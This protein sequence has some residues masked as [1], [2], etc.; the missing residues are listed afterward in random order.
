MVT[1][2]NG[3]QLFLRV[4]QLG[5]WL[6]LVF[7]V[8]GQIRA[9]DDGIVLLDTGAEERS[10]EHYAGC[11]ERELKENRLKH[12]IIDR[13]SFRDAL[14]PFF[15]PNTS[16]SNPKDMT[17]L[18]AKPRVA[19]TLVNLGVRYVVTEIWEITQEG[20]DSGFMFCA[21]EAGCWGLGTVEKT[22]DMSLI[23]WD[24]KNP[25]RTIAPDISAKGQD[26][27]VGFILPIPFLAGTRSG[28]CKEMAK[29]IVKFINSSEIQGTEPDSR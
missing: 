14:F 13:A 4:I 19:K 28:A 11:L 27:W 29:Q 5:I 6:V 1:T 7:V 2:L 3:H 23:I 15:E 17:T 18:L 16:P 26:V 8:T 20:D 10:M 9:A 25:E 12:E 21:M 24:L 22:T